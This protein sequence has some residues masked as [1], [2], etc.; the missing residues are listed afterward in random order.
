MNSKIKG[1][2]KITNTKNN[3]VYIGS[4]IDI[5]KRWQE[6]INSLKKNRHH[7]AKLQRSYNATSDKTVFNF[8]LIEE[9]EDKSILFTREQYYIDLFDAFKSGYNC[10]GEVNNPRY[11]EKN[12][13]KAKKSKQKC[14]F[15]DEFIEIYSKYKDNIY[16]SRSFL[17]KLESQHYSA[18]TYKN[19]NCIINWFMENYGV[20]YHASINVNSNGKYYLTIQDSD[21]QPFVCYGY[22][23]GK[24]VNSEYDTNPYRNDLKIKGLLQEDMHYIII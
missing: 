15:F 18:D 10:C 20:L 4:S 12:V 24:F 21:H 13:E 1:I 19:V 9:V 2:Y 17:D 22:R 14:K 7:S 23:S 5:E 16:V 3:K 6:H 11:T 8:E